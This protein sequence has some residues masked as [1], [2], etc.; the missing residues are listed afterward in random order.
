MA[1]APTLGANFSPR[2]SDLTPPA[3]HFR[4]NLSRRGQQPP[5]LSLPHACGAS[6]GR[7]SRLKPAA[8]PAR[9]ASRAL[10]P[11]TPRNGGR[12]VLRR[13]GPGG[14]PRASLAPS[15]AAASPRGP[16]ER[17]GAALTHLGPVVRSSEA[18]ERRRGMDEGGP[19]GRASEAA[20]APLRAPCWGRRAAATSW[21]RPAPIRS[22]PPR[23]GTARPRERH[24][25]WP[26]PGGGEAGLWAG[27]GAGGGVRREGVRRGGCGSSPAPKLRFHLPSRAAAAG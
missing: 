24:R 23:H 6:P 27:L 2:S 14:S 26:G 15:G 9:A 17:R 7:L 10:T 25:G 8:V 19:G 11:L 18:A 1:Q 12:G 21:G 3:R 16:G 4:S 22:D 5:L 13:R 20:A